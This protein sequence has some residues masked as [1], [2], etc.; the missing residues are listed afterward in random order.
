MVIERVRVRVRVR[1]HQRT[2]IIPKQMSLS[3]V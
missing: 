3:G 2:T 1:A